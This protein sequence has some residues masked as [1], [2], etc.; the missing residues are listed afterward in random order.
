MKS[1]RRLLSRVVSGS[2]LACALLWSGAV[3]E[4]AAIHGPLRVGREN[5]RYFADARGKAVYL[6][7]SHTWSNLQDQGTT[8]PPPPFEYARYLDFMVAH[9]Q[10]FMRMWAGEHF[11]YRETNRTLYAA[12]LPWARTGPG[13]ARDGKPRFD[14]SRFDESYFRRLRA[15]VK[16]A[17]ARGIYVSIMLFEG[18]T[19]QFSPRPTAPITWEGSPFHPANNINGI[20]GN[21]EGN[22]YGSACYTL[23]V[24]EITR[25]QEAY[26]R[27]V[28]DTVNDLGNV[29]YEIVNETGGYST[30][31]QYHMIR[32]VKQYEATKPVQ[33][34]V[35]MTFQWPNGTNE[36]LFASPADWISP[37]AGDTEG[38]SYLLNPRPADGRKVILPDSDH[39]EGRT[40]ENL[41]GWVWK[42]ACR[43]LNPIYMDFADEA[44]DIAAGP[45]FAPDHPDPTHREPV[46]RALGQARR[47]VERMDLNHAQPAGELASSGYCLANPGHQYLVYLPEGGP[48]MVDLSAVKGELIAEWFDP[49]GEKTVAKSRVSGG[50]KAELAAPLA[51]EAVLFLHRPGQ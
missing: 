35:G 12:P 2:L 6:T 38:F 50:K 39:L 21:P 16:A 3:S 47:L 22:G 7:G 48:V 41:R 18:L 33:H 13:L 32:F 43:G 26:V 5:P 40:P 20:D 46:R 4:G 30:E 15:R 1:T 49:V 37:R 17:G 11:R 29:L 28:V 44:W 36:H 42:S 45:Q 10:N 8:D 19:D 25:L 51:G 24:P 23:A 31:W 34:P 9:H 27:H 14:L